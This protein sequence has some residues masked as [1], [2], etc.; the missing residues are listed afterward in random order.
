MGQLVLHQFPLSHFCE[1]IRW[2]LDLKGAPYVVK[3]QLPGMHAV[4]NRR[5]VGRGSVPLLVDGHHAIGNSS[6]IALY[7]EDQYPEPCLIPRDPQHRAEVLELEAYFDCEV[8]PAVRQWIYSYLVWHPAM[9]GRVFFEE[10]TG[11]ARVVGKLAS[12]A[13][14][15]RIASMYRTSP[16]GREEASRAM[17][18]ALAGIEQRIGDD[19]SR[20]LVGD[21]LTLADVTAASL[22]GPL[23]GPPESPW[24]LDLALPKVRARREAAR[25]RPAGR[26]VMERYAHDR[27]RLLGKHASP[28]G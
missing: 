7:L 11:L 8:G 9:F 27:A 16:S 10:Y 26:W 24:A 23:L 13:V 1:K 2:V 28:A 20:Y 18:S 19:P 25:A 6:D 12:G 22:L 5:L 17:D 4:V 3:N 14:A 15:L 21:M